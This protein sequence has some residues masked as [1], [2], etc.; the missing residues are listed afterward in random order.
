VL[1]QLCCVVFLLFLVFWVAF[2]S[3]GFE[4]VF[5]EILVERETMATAEEERRREQRK[6]DSLLHHG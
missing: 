2:V 6:D 5:K 3:F 4:R 1:Q